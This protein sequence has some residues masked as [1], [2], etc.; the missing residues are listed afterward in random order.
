MK[1][2]PLRIRISCPRRIRGEPIVHLLTHDCGVI[3]NLLRGRLTRQDA[4][5]ELELSGPRKNLRKALN[6]LRRKGVRVRRLEPRDQPTTLRGRRTPS[7]TS[8]IPRKRPSP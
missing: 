8:P 5:L 3:P 2:A 7:R 6:F 4:W 1:T